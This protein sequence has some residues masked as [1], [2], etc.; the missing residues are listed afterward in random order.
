[1]IKVGVVGR[2]ISGEEQGRY[3]RIQK[4]P[5]DPPSYLVL[6]AT[7]RN[8]EREGGD[9]WVEDESSLIQFFE[10]SRWVVQWEK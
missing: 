3:V 5:D 10:E 6:T 7:D 4:L 1:M 2:I 9:A 8:F